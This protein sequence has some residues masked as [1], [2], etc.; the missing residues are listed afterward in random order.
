MTY[1]VDY[2]L[3][4]FDAIPDEMWCCGGFSWGGKMCALGHC[5]VTH[6]S[7]PITPESLAL[8][9]LFNENLGV[10]VARVNDANSELLYNNLSKLVEL[11]DTPKERII[12]ALILIK[13]GA[14]V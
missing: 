3:N 7:S 6:Y 12:S 8:A 9:R 1:D 13:A 2:F 10:D 4:K 5:G 11:G 14:S